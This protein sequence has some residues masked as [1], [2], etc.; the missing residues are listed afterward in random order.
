MSLLPSCVKNVVI[1]NNG[2]TWFLYSKRR[3]L[4]Q[5]YG[6]F[7][8]SDQALFPFLDGAWGRGYNQSVH[9]SLYISLLDLPSPPPQVC[10]FLPTQLFTT[11]S[12]SSI[13]RIMLLSWQHTCLHWKGEEGCSYCGAHTARKCVAN[14]SQNQRRL[15]NTC[16]QTDRQTD[17][18]AD[19]Q[20]DRQTD[21]QTDRQ[22][23]AKFYTSSTSF[24]WPSAHYID[25][26]SSI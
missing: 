1:G 12:Q 2:R 15:S 8:K 4:T 24:F 9:G 23:E 25:Y 14:V 18:Q 3:L 10:S 5:Q 19:R 6:N 17:R 16:R 22:R 21:R 20:K 11:A 13:L 7:C 26:C